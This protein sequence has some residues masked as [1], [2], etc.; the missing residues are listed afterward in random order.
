MDRR[1][2]DENNINGYATK[3]ARYSMGSKIAGPVVIIAFGERE[4]K[5]IGTNEQGGCGHTQ[6]ALIGPSLIA[7][8]REIL[9]T[10]ELR[11]ALQSKGNCFLCG[12]SLKGVLVCIVGDVQ[13]ADDLNPIATELGLLT[14][15]IV[16]ITKDVYGGRYPGFS[17]EQIEDASNRV[18]YLR[19]KS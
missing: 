6:F 18:I 13:D 16:F 10:S 11:N 15:R 5:I 9:K 17:R 1:I 4:H 14:S 2:F 7:I 8:F 3:S 12:E 19:V